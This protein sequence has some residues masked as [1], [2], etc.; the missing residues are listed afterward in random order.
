MTCSGATCRLEHKDLVTRGSGNIAIKKIG[1]LL[2]ENEIMKQ[3]GIPLD[4]SMR[5][6]DRLRVR[7]IS[8]IHSG[9]ISLEVINP[10]TCSKT[11]RQVC[12]PNAL[13]VCELWGKL[14]S[15]E[16]LMIEGTHM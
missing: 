4:T 10:L 3:L 14:T 5:T 1:N 11:V 13:Y 9:C 12:Y 15:T 7:L 16:T 8:V 6:M 2:L